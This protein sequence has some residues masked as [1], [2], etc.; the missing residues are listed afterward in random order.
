MTQTGCSDKTTPTLADPAAMMIDES[1][2]ITANRPGPY[3]PFTQKSASGLTATWLPFGAH[4]QSVQLPDGTSILAGYNAPEDYADGGPYL[5]SLIGRV[6]NRIN[7]AS[8]A[9]DEQAYTVADNENGHTLHGGP[10]GF[11]RRVWDVRHEG[12]DRV[13]RHTSP[14]GHQG[15]P[16]NLDVTV[17]TTVSDR[18]L[19]VKIIAITDAPTPVN[20]S[21]HGYWN[22]AGLFDRPIDQL[23]LTS[24]ADRYT[25]VGDDLIPTGETRAVDDTAYDFRAMR[26][27]G[28]AFLDVNLLVPGDGLREMAQLSDGVRSVTILSDYPGLQIY[29]GEALDGVAS[30]SARGALAMEPQ[31]P[32]DAVNQ[33]VDG[34]DTI[35]RPGEVYR[36]TIIYR[37]DGP[38]F[39]DP[40]LQGTPR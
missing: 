5:G 4:L 19:R 12:E 11:D 10:N 30:L 17:R 31:Y 7:G 16:G 22:P 36:H 32:P 39:S 29:S 25:V 35:L 28:P 40:T 15:Y 24:P 8:F 26:P 6:A 21:Q 13:F 33:P 38:G 2:S 37:F 34:N 14:A 27:I 9:I 18:E 3:T 1:T 20:L 23:Q